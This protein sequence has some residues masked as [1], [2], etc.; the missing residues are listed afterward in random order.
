MIQVQTGYLPY[1]SPAEMSSKVP[2]YLVIN[3][4]TKTPETV[5][6]IIWHVKEKDKTD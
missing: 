1:L 4:I 2:A 6:L 5:Q 3:E